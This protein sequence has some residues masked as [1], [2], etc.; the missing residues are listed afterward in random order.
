MKPPHIFGWAVLVIVLP[1]FTLSCDEPQK[2]DDP[3]FQENLSSFNSTMTKL[4]STMDLMDRLQENVDKIEEDKAMGRISDE[5]AL[6]KLNELNNTLGRKI[7]RTSNFHPVN[8]LPAWA[9]QLGLTEPDGL[10]FDKDFSETTSEYNDSEGYNSVLM[11]YN[12]NYQK[13]ME[14]AA[15]IAQKAGIPL[16]KD[17]KDAME[18]SEKYGVETI[19]GAVYLNFD[20]GSENNPRYNI[21]I[22]VDEEGTLTIGATDTKMMMKQLKSVYDN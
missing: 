4:D 1:F 22:T 15:I 2:E 9:R 18:L 3:D 10:I 11:V 17:Y 21:S 13:S 5:E 6:E 7:A 20:L 14:Q 19:K 12:G 8:G 16:S